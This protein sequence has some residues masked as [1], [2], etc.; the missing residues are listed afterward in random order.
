MPSAL[1]KPVSGCR[2][3][4]PSSPRGG[5]SASSALASQH[6]LVT[7]C[8]MPHLHPGAAASETAGAH[9]ASHLDRGE[10]LAGGGQ[11]RAGTSRQGGSFFPVAGKHP[12]NSQKGSAFHARHVY[13]SEKE[14]RTSPP[15]K[16]QYPRLI[17]LCMST[18]FLRIRSTGVL[19]RSSQRPKL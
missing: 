12:Q 18:H 8:A 4:A 6:Q 1:L 13:F 2:W 10:S 14:P 19:L 5:P 7:G 17:S 9:L 16:P 11:R 3:E 15:H